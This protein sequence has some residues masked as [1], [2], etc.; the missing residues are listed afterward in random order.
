MPESIFEAVLRVAKTNG[1]T[2][3]QANQSD[4]AFL[5][6]IVKALA[7]CADQEWDSLPV[8]AHEWYNT[9]AKQNNAGKQISNPEGFVSALAKPAPAKVQTAKPT[10]AEK[11]V[12]V[13]PPPPPVVEQK[14]RT[15]RNKNAGILDAIR[16][17]IILNP[18]LNA[19]QVHEVLTK[20]GFP[21]ASLAIVAVNTGDVKRVIALV[22]ELG[23]WKEPVNAA[24][25]KTA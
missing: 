16:K 25:K 8:T 17:T 13:I 9:V 2:A 7:S 23:Y 22:Q 4:Q 5:F 19:K 3:Q 15:K 20:V 12:T 14:E 1:G 21:D 11:P 24:E 18:N 10:P 6:S